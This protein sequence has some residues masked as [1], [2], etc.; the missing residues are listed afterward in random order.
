MTDV[1]PTVVRPVRG[2]GTP[3]IETSDPGVSVTVEAE[4]DFVTG[5]ALTP[6]GRRVVASRQRGGPVAFDAATA[7]IART[8]DPPAPLPNAGPHSGPH[9]GS[10]CGALSPDGARVG[11]GWRSGGRDG[12]V[13]VWSLDTGEDL[14]QQDVG[15]RAAS[16]PTFIPDGARLSAGDPGGR[17]TLRD[18]ETAAVL[19]Q[20]REHAGTNGNGL[21]PV[22]FLPGG[23]APSVGFDG[24]V[25]LWDVTSAEEPARLDRPGRALLNLAP[26][27]GGERFLTGGGG[28]GNGRA[29]EKT[30]GHALRLWRL[31]GANDAVPDDAL[32]E[33]A[34]RFAR[35]VERLLDAVAEKDFRDRT[36]DLAAEYFGAAE[37]LPEADADR[38]ARV[39]TR[40]ARKLRDS[41]E[42]DRRLTELLADFGV[43]P[44][45]GEAPEV[46]AGA[47]PDLLNNLRAAPPAE[48]KPAGLVEVRRFRGG[49]VGA[50]HAVAVS[51]D[52]A[53]LVSGA[54]D[55]TA[56]LR[57]VA[58][59]KELRALLGHRAW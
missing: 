45:R 25:R 29:I 18:L 32:P 23:R 58:T 51:G 4:G 3:V 42:P 26:P 41:P 9:V 21:N 49:H 6:D 39:L 33:P 54:T 27:P 15:D 22:A 12:G 53:R 55:G 5:L 56:R 40:A 57:D 59:G 34:E 30:G 1:S 43:A 52:E 11:A 8:F 2:D 31:P 24:T 44:P 13:V 50:V 47:F 20:F 10:N 17:L 7:R 37:A 46:R 19:R 16:A 48:A 28:F 36:P 14:F 35:S 38:L